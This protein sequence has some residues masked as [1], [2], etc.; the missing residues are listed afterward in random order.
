MQRR[1]LAPGLLVLVGLAIGPVALGQTNM[2]TNPRFADLD[3]DT[4]YGDGWGSFGN[5]G[6]GDI[7]GA[8]SANFFGDFAGNAGGLYQQGIPGTPGV[9]YQFELLDAR[10]EVW[11]DADLLFGLEYYAADD[12]AKLGE[13]LVPIDTAARILAGQVDG[14]VLS[15]QGTAIPGTAFVRPIILFDNVNPAYVGQFNASFFIFDTFLR[16]APTLGEEYLKNAGFE[17]VD[18]DAIVGDYWSSYGA[19][20]FHAFFDPGNGHAS[21]FADDPNNVGGVYQQAILATPGESY[22]F[23]LTNVRIEAD[24]DGELFMALEFYAADDATKLGET[25]RQIGPGVTGDGLRFGIIGRAPAGAVYVRPLVRFDNVLTVGA[26]S[27]VFIFD[28][29]LTVLAPSINLLYNRGFEDLDGNGEYG[30]GWGGWSN[31]SFDSFWGVNGHASLYG[32]VFQNYGGVFQVA[33]PGEP[34]KTY[35]LDLLD[36]R[37]EEFW[38][39]DLFAGFEYYAADDATKLGESMTLLDTAA[40]LALGKIDGNFLSVQGTAVAG[41]VIVRPVVRFEN[42]NENYFFQPQA[43]LFVFDAYMSIAPE[44]GEEHLKNPGFADVDGD[45]AFGDVWSSFGAA[46]FNEFFGAGNPHAS[47]FA[48]DPNNFGGFYQQAILSAAGAAYRFDLSNVRIEENFDADLFFGLEFYGG[49]DDVKIGEVIQPIDTSVTGDGLSFSV[50]GTAVAGTVYVRPIVFFD[51]V[52]SAGEQRG[53]FVFEASL[54][55]LPFL[56]GD[57]DGNGRVDFPDFIALGD[58]LSGPDAVP[59]SQACLDGFDSDADG[60]VDVRDASV[61]AELY[62]G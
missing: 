22:R 9:T 4:F 57:Y 41:T 49:D 55:E 31:V 28:A 60:D 46:G 50:T 59:A 53:A 1:I 15:M 37:I 6:F 33:I 34:G 43:S 58:C 10:I 3:N 21:L 24:F 40:R 61:F 2:I 42:V 23:D 7:F 62:E 11:R 51:N 12:A 45:G 18:G 35:Q 16:V 25:V 29:A 32:D 54:T 44:P 8:P 13:T 5:T 36:T 52:R 56:P 38:D 20:G 26:E 17:D 27:N 48:D 47:L 30:D 39:A 19:A 14:N